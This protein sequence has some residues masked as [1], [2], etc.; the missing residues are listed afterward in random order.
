MYPRKIRKT[1]PY[2]RPKKVKTYS[3]SKALAR[4]LGEEVS[5]D[6]RVRERKPSSPARLTDEEWEKLPAKSLNSLRDHMT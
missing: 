5:P 6:I 3:L 2:L 1:T 4:N